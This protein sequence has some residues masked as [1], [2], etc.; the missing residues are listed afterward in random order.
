MQS[1]HTLG[2]PSIM[3][4]EDFHTQVA[5]P[6][7][8]PFPSGGVRP[9]QPKSLSSQRSIHQQR[10]MSLLLLSPFHLLLIQLWLRRK[11]LHQSLFQSHP[12]HL[13]LRIPYHPHQHWSKSSPFHRI[14]QL[15]QCWILM[16]MQ[17]IT[18][19]RIDMIFIFLHFE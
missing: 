16:S 9:P 15:L 5:W 13:S 11:Y 3:S 4:M 14:H 10:K 2:L 8:Q 6:R 12:L 7:V 18:H 1:F 17:R 19:R